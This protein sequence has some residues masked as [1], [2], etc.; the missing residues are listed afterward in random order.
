M[1]PAVK[2]ERKKPLGN[3]DDEHVKK[4]EKLMIYRL[5]ENNAVKVVDSMPRTAYAKSHICRAT[6]EKGHVQMALYFKWRGN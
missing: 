6:I 2:R 5:N 4:H 1:N 3:R